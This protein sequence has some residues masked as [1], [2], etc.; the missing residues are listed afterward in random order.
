MLQKR[1]KTL[2]NSRISLTIHGFFSTI[3]IGTFYISQPSKYWDHLLK[4]YEIEKGKY[5]EKY[6]HGKKRNSYT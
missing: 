2:K 4:K 3:L 6:I 1:N 5:Y